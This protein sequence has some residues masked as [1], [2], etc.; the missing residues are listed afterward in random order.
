MPKNLEERLKRI[1]ERLTRTWILHQ[2]LWLGVKLIVPK[3]RF[4]AGVVLFKYCLLASVNLSDCSL[5]NFGGDAK[6]GFKW[7][8]CCL[9]FCRYPV[10]YVLGLNNRGNIGNKYLY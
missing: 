7:V 6:L 2:I 4:G 5:G 1:V 8:I 9:P 3:R 10:Q